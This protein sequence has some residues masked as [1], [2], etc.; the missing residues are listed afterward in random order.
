MLHC[1]LASLPF[2]VAKSWCYNVSQKVVSGGRIPFMYNQRLCP[3]PLSISQVPHFQSV[4]YASLF[5]QL[6]PLASLFLRVFPHPQSIPKAH[7]SQF[8]YILSN[9]K[10]LRLTVDTHGTPNLLSFQQPSRIGWEC[11]ISEFHPMNFMADWDF[12]TPTFQQLH[13]VALCKILTFT[14]VELAA[15]PFL[16]KADHR[17]SDNFI[18]WAVGMFISIPRHHTTLPISVR[19]FIVICIIQYI[20]NST[21]NCTIEKHNVFKNELIGSMP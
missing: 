9:S 2:R 5:P 4:A 21:I 13:H 1:F 18:P 6:F 14:T 7:Q 17:F 15:F 3:P 20:I 16:S 12:S 8:I 10:E 19:C 11:G